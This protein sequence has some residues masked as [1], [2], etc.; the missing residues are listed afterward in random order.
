M[1]SDNGMAT[2]RCLVPTAIKN[3]LEAVCAE[4]RQRN[5]LHY[6][7]TMAACLVIGVRAVSRSGA[8]SYLVLEQVR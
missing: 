7:Q 6:A 2:V 8:I 3:Q 1:A 5:G 4:Q